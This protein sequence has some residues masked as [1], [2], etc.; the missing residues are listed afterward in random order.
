MQSPFD[1]KNRLAAFLDRAALSAGL[2]AVCFLYFYFLW[3]SSTAS[4]VAGAALFSLLTL[5]LSLL[6]RRTLRRRDRLLREKAGGMI[7]LHELLLMPGAKADETVCALLCSV[8]GA[9]Q[10]GARMLYEGESWL[11]RV[12]ACLQGSS[13]GE[14]DVLS[15]HRAR[16]TSGAQR[17]VLISTGAFT[18]AAI[19]AAEW[20][21]PPVRLI[22]GRQLAMLFGRMHPA[23]DEEIARHARSCRRPFSFARMR[24]LALS[25]NKQPR[26]LSCALLL[27]ILYLLLDSMAAL[28]SC[29]LSFLLAIA[30]SR[31]NR[32]AFRL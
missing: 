18:P 8:L 29:L 4:L 17:C 9:K 13:A 2:F 23:S 19:R 5:T 14:G 16:I 7:A 32:R 11:V 21:E 1:T 31:E 26:Y 6:S 20:V 25:P 22:P 12:C 24:A 10:E 15:T 3:R 27:L 30:C 28:L